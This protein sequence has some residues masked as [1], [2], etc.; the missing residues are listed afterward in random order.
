MNTFLRSCLVRLR[1]Y[2]FKAK[3]NPANRQSIVPRMVAKLIPRTSPAAPPTSDRNVSIA[4]TKLFFLLP[5][6]KLT[7]ISNFNVTYFCLIMNI[8]HCC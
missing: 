4:K 7:I 8:Y 3:N 5:A 1:K 6:L 2:F